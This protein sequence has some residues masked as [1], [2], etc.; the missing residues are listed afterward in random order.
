MWPIVATEVARLVGGELVGDSSVMCDRC[1]IDTRVGVRRGD[2]FVGLVG[3]SRDGA[4]YV[5][6]AFASGAALALVARGSVGGASPPD[7]AALVVV[8]DTLEALQRLAC[9]ARDSFA[10]VVIAITGTHGKTTLKSMLRECAVTPRH[11]WTS[12]LSYN[13]QIGVALSLLMCDFRARAAVFECGVSRPGEMARLARMVRPHLGVL[14]HIGDAHLEEMGT[15]ETIATE[16]AE[17]FRPWGKTRPRVV[18]DGACPLSADACTNVG[19][20]VLRVTVEDG[21]R[22]ARAV[23]DTAAP[24]FVATYAAMVRAIAAHLA[25]DARQV[26]EGLRRWRSEPMRL[27]M[28]TTSRDVT[29]INDAYTSD[30][31]SLMAALRWLRTTSSHGRTVLVLGGMGDEGTPRVDAYAYIGEALAR[32]EADTLITIGDGGAA[33]AVAARDAGMSMDRI[34]SVPTSTEALEI[35]EVGIQPG[36]RVLVKGARRERL[37]TVVDRLLSDLAPA[38]LYVDMDAIVDNYRWIRRKV[39]PGVGVMGVVKSFGYGVDAP[40]VALA[41]QDAGADYVAVAYADEGIQLRDRGVTIPILVHN[42]LPHE[43]DKIARHGLSAVLVSDAQFT[44]LRSSALRFSTR[45]PL[46][47]KI[48]TGMTRAGFSPTAAVDVASRVDAEP[49]F[50]LEGV[51]THLANADDPT[52]DAVTQ[53]QLAEFRCAV[54]ALRDL[55]LRPRWIHACNSSGLRRFPDAHWTM[56]RSGIGL[57]GYGNVPGASLADGEKA[58][59]RLVTRVIS[60]RDVAEGARVGY[61]GTFRVTS[62]TTRIAV[63]G[64]GY[65]DGYLRALSNVGWMSV[66]GTRCRVVGRVCMDV[67]MIDV[68]AV[69]GDVSPGDEVVVFGTEE[70]EPDLV[71]MAEAAGTI[72]YELLT[73]ISPR[74]RRVYLRTAQ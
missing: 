17:L 2:I 74:V 11:V 49:C 72:A 47:L 33:L 27:E 54:S 63:V 30:A 58:T 69:R 7:G 21:S 8:D 71:E 70:G 43:S 24:A 23:D 36:D 59:L 9:H 39:G 15:R 5:E 50:T 44:S 62:E 46:H 48:D 22:D 52:L 12:P 57:L 45:I 64:I 31:T 14:T 20:E 1:I 26:A 25:W 3:A 13:S 6:R 42:V 53:E 68:S 19:A 18:V 73:R 66:Q 10:G 55:D 60:V 34:V 38:L 65:G 51:M 35:L 4:S 29:I 28:V 16:K 41:L 40:R 56:V 61:G 67:T 32:T 37:E